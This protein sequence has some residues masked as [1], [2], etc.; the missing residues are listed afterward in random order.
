MAVETATVGLSDVREYIRVNGDVESKS[1][2]NIYP[3]VS[4]K[5]TSLN[6]SL[7]EMP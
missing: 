7:W 2:V 5:I 3:D 1:S 4:G 6:V